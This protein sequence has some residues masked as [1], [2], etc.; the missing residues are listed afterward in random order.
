M[1]PVPTG[2]TLDAHL[3]RALHTTSASMEAAHIAS[4]AT[5]SAPRDTSLLCTWS[6]ACS[7][8]ST[9]AKPHA[10]PCAASVASTPRVTTN[11]CAG[12]ETAAICWTSAT[13]ASMASTEGA[14]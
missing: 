2:L 11:T 8:R 6:A 14:A 3:A 9:R 12:D 5:E 4:N 13:P 10:P 7:S 1:E